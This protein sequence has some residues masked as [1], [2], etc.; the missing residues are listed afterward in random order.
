MKNIDNST[1]GNTESNLTILSNQ[2]PIPIK[3]MKHVYLE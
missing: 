1:S 2:S 3:R